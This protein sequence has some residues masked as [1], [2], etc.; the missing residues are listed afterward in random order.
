MGP[1]RAVNIRLLRLTSYLL[2]GAVLAV[3]AVSALADPTARAGDGRGP[4]Q[5]ALLVYAGVYVV[6]G[7][8]LISKRPREP[9]PWLLL[10]N[11]MI[12]S[13][14]ASSWLG[15]VFGSEFER[16]AG[17]VLYLAF[18]MA[19]ALLVQLF[20]TGHRLPGR[21]RWV[22][23]LLVVGSMVFMLGQAAGVSVPEQPTLLTVV[24]VVAGA[25]FAVGMLG[26]VP[27][28][29]VRFRR[30]SGVER[31]QL[32][33]YLFGV[34]VAVAFWFSPW[35]LLAAFAPM[36]PVGA[37]MVALLR[38]HLFDIDRVISRTAAYAVVTGCLVSTY[39]LLVTVMSRLL[40]DV[41]GGL[42]SGAGQPSI[43]VASATLASAAVARP[44]LRRVQ[45]SVDRRFDRARYDAART[46]DE[47]GARLRTLAD[48]ATVVADLRDVVQRTVQ[49]THQ[50]L[51]VRGSR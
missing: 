45:S 4:F 24:I 21:W 5:T 15:Q 43:V 41:V 29:L 46:V 28:L 44:I 3:A 18:G 38:Y 17:V 27:V 12:Y 11:G 8:V 7:L 42:G 22:T 39:V 9:L 40:P 47:F 23:D 33:W 34:T 32:K 10:A 19:S 30:S 1:E 50:T 36:L 49:P 16:R 2:G 6:I 37:I 26:S 14:S 48:P 51:W 20:P 35:P 13:L 31:A 25:A